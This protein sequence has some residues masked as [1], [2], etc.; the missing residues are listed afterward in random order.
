MSLT[1]TAIKVTVGRKI[2]TLPKYQKIKWS[3]RENK[4]HT[5]RHI[6]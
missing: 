1:D 6:V 5:E 2:G 3:E 4:N